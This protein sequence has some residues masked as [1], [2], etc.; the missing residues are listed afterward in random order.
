MVDSLE[1]VNKLAY[2]DGVNPAPSV[3]F[4]KPQGYA[5]FV[6][7]VSCALGGQIAAGECIELN[8]V[9]NGAYKDGGPLLLTYRQAKIFDDGSDPEKWYEIGFQFKGWSKREMIM[10]VQLERRN[11]VSTYGPPSAQDLYIRRTSGIPE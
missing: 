8:C 7:W 5:D 11:D 10:T 9:I 6:V 2:I 1:R 4:T 3:V